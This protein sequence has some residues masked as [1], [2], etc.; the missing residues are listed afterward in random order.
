MT[1]CLLDW[2]SGDGSDARRSAWGGK[3]GVEE[4][5]AQSSVSQ[6]WASVSLKPTPNRLH[7]YF[8]PCLLLHAHA[9]CSLPAPPIKQEGSLE[10]GKRT[11]GANTG[12]SGWVSNRHQ[13]RW[14]RPDIYNNDF[15]FL[16]EA[17]KFLPSHPILD[18]AGLQIRACTGSRRP[19]RLGRSWRWSVLQEER[20]K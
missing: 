16:K 19:Q 11:I 7:N 18:T 20:V 10:R 3:G 1:L 14:G 12:F 4:I 15:P 2:K 13:E 5:R 9:A 17:H 6:N 8:C